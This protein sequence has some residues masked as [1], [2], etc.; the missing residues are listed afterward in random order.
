MADPRT[1]RSAASRSMIRVVWPSPCDPE[2]PSCLLFSG[3]HRLHRNGISIGCARN[4]S[5]LPSQLVEF[6]KRGLIRGIEGINLVADYQSV[7]SAFL[8][9]GTNA[10]CGGDPL[11]HV[12]RSAPLLPSKLATFGN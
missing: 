7:L 12:R 1:L 6:V 4:F 10:I 9:A 11:F 2:P 3:S 8:H 5:L